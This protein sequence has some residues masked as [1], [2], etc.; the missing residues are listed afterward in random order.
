ME[1]ASKFT[2]LDLDCANGVPSFPQF[3]RA[4]D[5]IK[6][7]VVLIVAV[8]SASI[9]FIYSRSFKSLMQNAPKIVKPNCISL[10][11]I[12][13]IVSVCS[14]IA[15]LVPRAYFFMDTIGHCSFMIISYQLYR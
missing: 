1:N 5:L 12:Y 3:I 13:P 8:F 2:D 7:L 14:M 15:I 6:C 4:F 11:S 10:I 9:L